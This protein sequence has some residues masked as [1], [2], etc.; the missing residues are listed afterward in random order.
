MM[1]ILRAHDRK[2][3]IAIDE[4]ANSPAMRKFVSEFQL[5][6]RNKYPIYLLM[7]GLYDNLYQLHNEKTLTFLYRAPKIFLSPLNMSAV[8]E[9]YRTT[10]HNSEEDARQM[11]S[12]TKGYSYAYQVVGYLCWEED[13]GKITERIV[14]RFDM[15]M[16]EY[17]YSKIWEEQSPMKRKILEATA[18]SG[19]GDVTSIRK[20]ISMPPSEFGVY[21]NRLMRQGLIQPEGYGKISFVLPRFDVYIRNQAFDC[22]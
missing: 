19:T 18:R 4:A 6:L 21:R 22:M 12:L 20:Q 10:F 5:L 11:A 3:L 16:E 9:S 14:S 8:T 17:V 13:S 7:A 1:E 15:F 2:L